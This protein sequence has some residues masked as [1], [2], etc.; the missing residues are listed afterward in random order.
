MIYDKYRKLY[1]RIAYPKTTIEKNV[2]GYELREYGRKY[3]TI[4]ILDDKFNIILVL[5]LLGKMVFIFVIVII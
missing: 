5:F 1:Y 2:K 3:F 4:I